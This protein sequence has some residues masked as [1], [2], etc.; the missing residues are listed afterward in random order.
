MPEAGPFANRVSLAQ[1]VALRRCPWGGHMAGS[2]CRLFCPW[3]P[4]LSA[5]GTGTPAS[6]MHVEKRCCHANQ[7][8]PHTSKPQ[9]HTTSRGR[10]TTS[11]QAPLRVPGCSGYQCQGSVL[12]RKLR[13]ANADLMRE[14]PETPWWCRINGRNGS[15]ARDEHVHPPPPPP[16]KT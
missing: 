12:V 10:A 15:G 3:C 16:A 13:K 2:R 1:A 5:T 4:M 14:N 11:T 9:S 7:P 8:I 6:P